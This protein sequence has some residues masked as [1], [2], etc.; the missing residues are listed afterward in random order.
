MRSGRRP[1]LYRP[2]GGSAPSRSG[3]LGVG[4]RA[5]LGVGIESV[6]AAAGKGEARG[7]EACVGRKPGR[8]VMALRVESAGPT[9]SSN[10]AD[11]G[12]WQPRQ[13]DRWRARLRRHPAVQT[14]RIRVTGWAGCCQQT[15]ATFPPSRR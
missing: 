6:G 9:R 15:V 12:R 4:G 11:R 8:S 7:T 10:G 2:E 1:G 13:G 3:L 5:M 14:G